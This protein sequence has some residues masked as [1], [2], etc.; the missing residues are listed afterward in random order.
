MNTENEE[1]IDSLRQEI[2]QLR[3]WLEEIKGIAD[4]SDGIVGWHLN[5]DVLLWGQIDCW[6]EIEELLKSK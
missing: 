3:E 1:L 2:K 5:N 4:E 6:S